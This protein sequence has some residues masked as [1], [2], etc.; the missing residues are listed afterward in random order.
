[1]KKFLLFIKYNQIELKLLY[2][3]CI[4]LRS[5][6]ITSND[7]NT[8]ENAILLEIFDKNFYTIVDFF[9]NNRNQLLK[10][11]DN[12]I[13]IASHELRTPLTSIKGYLSMIIDG[14]I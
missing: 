11:K 13:S 14:D 5:I 6:I 7:F 10:L 9:E 8:Q 12:F 3:F 2:N 4:K 1:M